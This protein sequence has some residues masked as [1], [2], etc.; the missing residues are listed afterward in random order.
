MKRTP[1]RLAALARARGQQW[2][3]HARVLAR[4]ALLGAAGATGALPVTLL[5]QH[6]LHR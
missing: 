4:R 6:L 5:A 3:P 2:R 1:E